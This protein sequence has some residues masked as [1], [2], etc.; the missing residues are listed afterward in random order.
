MA[1]ISSNRMEW[2][3]A[4]YGAFSLGA[5]YVPMYEQQRVSE[6]E[7]ILKDSGAK[8]LLVSKERIYDKVRLMTLHKFP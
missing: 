2:A 8:L 6:C 5:A 1:V 7:Y 3:V 4:A